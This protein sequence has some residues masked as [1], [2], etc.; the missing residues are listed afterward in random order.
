MCKFS[1]NLWFFFCFDQAYNLWFNSPVTLSCS[2]QPATVT[3]SFNPNPVTPPSGGSVM[4]ML[5]LEPTRFLHD[6]TFTLNVFGTDGIHK[7]TTT[8]V[9]TLEGFIS[10]FVVPESAIGTIALVGTSLGAI[11][12]YMFLKSRKNP[13]S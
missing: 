13:T 9:P 3:C 2:D 12:G 1:I 5:V 8:T 11:G 10:F 7:R 4:S 6:M